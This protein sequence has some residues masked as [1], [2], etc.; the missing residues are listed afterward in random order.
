[1]QKCFLM[2]GYKVYKKK[3]GKLRMQKFSN[4]IHTTK[5]ICGMKL[6]IL[7]VL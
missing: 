3:V 1:M 4:K 7:I 2:N 6:N 5:V